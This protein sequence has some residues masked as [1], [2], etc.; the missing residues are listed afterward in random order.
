MRP[1]S[2]TLLRAQPDPFD[3]PSARYNSVYS[4]AAEEIRQSGI[5]EQGRRSG[6][7]LPA[8]NAYTS[9]SHLRSA[10]GL[11]NEIRD[12]SFPDLQD[13]KREGYGYTPPAPTQYEPSRPFTPSEN[14]PKGNYAQPN[15]SHEAYGNSGPGQSPYGQADSRQP[16]QQPDLQGGQQWDPA[17]R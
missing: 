1:L 16:R 11:R 5:W 8:S 13:R 14:S 12:D 6:E 9:S 10:S 15:Y 17:Y 2:P 3:S 7:D 4:T